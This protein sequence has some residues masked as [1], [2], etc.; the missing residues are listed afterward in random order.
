MSE[1][2]RSSVYSDETAALKAAAHLGS[3]S[4]HW[5]NDGER[6]PTSWYADSVELSKSRA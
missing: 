4:N 1:D 3:G 6:T 2:R 5:T